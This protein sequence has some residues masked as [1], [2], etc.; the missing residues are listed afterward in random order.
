[1]MLTGR[2][3]GPPL[4][5]PRGVVELM[6]HAA[7]VLRDHADGRVDIDGLALLGERAAFEG[8][9]RR[10]PESCG[11]GARLLPVADGWIAVSLA[12]PDDVASLPAWL[13]LDVG[14]VDTWDQIGRAILNLST[15]HLDARAALL[16]LPIAA[17]G[18]V[19][20]S[21]ADGLDLPASLGAL[22]VVDLSSLWA[23]PLCGS[24]LAEAG[25]EVIKVEATTRPDGARRG[26]RAFFNLLNGAKQSVVIDFTLASGVDQLTALLKSADVVIESARP[27]GLEQ[28][29]VMAADLLAAPV[30]PKVWV[31]ITSHGRS[32]GSVN[33]VGF[34]DVAAVAGGLVAVDEGGPTFLADA[35][36]D[37]MAGL[38]AAA[39]ALQALARAGSYL[40]D[41][42]MAPMAATVAGP[43]LDVD[44]LRASPPWARRPIRSARD[45][46][47]DTQ[48][49][50]SSL[51]EP[52]RPV[53]KL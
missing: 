37:P 39:G 27:R 23:G 34:G 33:R 16:G 8:L 10:G 40:L 6:D 49:V 2:A 9:R 24:L 15:D 41:V 20:P 13:E 26:N 31:S 50:L 22:R 36:T 29:G 25:A 4:G 11:G 51:G 43:L 3:N 14:S 46:G 48:S 44:G 21:E 19:P 38:V 17:L 53:R 47:A 7:A 30:G 42:G 32:A 45:M 35:I 1:M 12:R 18:S 52:E 5:A 28:L